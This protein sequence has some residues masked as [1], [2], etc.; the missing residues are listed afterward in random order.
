[1]LV[2]EISSVNLMFSL[3][4]LLFFL[5]PSLSFGLCFN[6]FVSCGRADGI[7]QK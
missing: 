4:L 6:S 7:A 2:C 1:M 3:W 5:N